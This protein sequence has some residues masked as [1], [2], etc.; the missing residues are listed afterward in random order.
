MKECIPL[1]IPILGISAGIIIPKQ[2]SFGN[3]AHEKGNRSAVIEIQSNLGDPSRVDE[4]LTA[5]STK[6]KKRQ[7]TEEVPA[8]AIAF[9][10]TWFCSDATKVKA[11]VGLLICAI[12]GI[13]N[14]LIDG[15]L[16]PNTSEELTNA[17]E[18]TVKEKKYDN[19]LVVQLFNLK[20]LIFLKTK[21]TS[22]ISN[23]NEIFANTVH[24]G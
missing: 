3:T 12:Q 13:A 19:C 2:Y 17:V 14:K 20:F 22:L 10:F 24:Q 15:Y 21:L 4:L 7:I 8:L 16:Y 11:S 6:E 5:L 23:A 1:I 18:S 9:F